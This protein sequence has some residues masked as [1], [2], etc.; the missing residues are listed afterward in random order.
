MDQDKS[1]FMEEIIGTNC[2]TKVDTLLDDP[3]YN[4]V[5]IPKENDFLSAENIGHEERKQEDLWT[6]AQ[7]ENIEGSKPEVEG[8]DEVVTENKVETQK[9]NSA[10]N[11][12]K[13][14]PT[15]KATNSQRQKRVIKKNKK[16]DKPRTPSRRSNSGESLADLVNYILDKPKKRSRKE[17]S[18]RRDVINKRILRG[19]KK[20]IAKQFDS[21]RIRPWRMKGESNHF[22][23]ALV[24]NAARIGLLNQN[25]ETESSTNI[26]EFK[27]FICWMAMSKNTEKT[28][29]LF[30][31]NNKSINLLGDVLAKYSHGKLESLY[32]DINISKV[33]EYFVINGM[34]E[35]L[36][37]IPKSKK[38]LYKETIATMYTKFNS[39][40]S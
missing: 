17:L 19:L 13:P 16:Q 1:L 8:Q 31:Y 20:Y 28:K 5:P 32:K 38:E 6:D 24:E 37:S 21:V 30:D 18:I 35:F 40:S 14:L 34:K 25:I 10:L 23:F 39:N 27:E 12:S 2:Q 26:E 9:N 36:R 22:K 33:F 15:K 11:I 4:F 29:S 3:F 7:I